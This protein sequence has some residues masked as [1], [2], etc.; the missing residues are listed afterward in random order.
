VL[1]EQVTIRLDTK[2]LAKLR[3]RAKER[4][5]GEAT[6]LARR[7]I[8]EGL[9]MDQYPGIVF[10]DGAAGRRPAL[11]GRRLG[12]APVVETL[13]ASNNDRAAT[14]EYFEIP[15]KEVEIAIAYYVDHKE[16]ID[17]WLE[18]QHKASLEQREAWERQ[19]SL[20]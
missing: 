7:Y 16:E 8:E 6:V 17:G 5:N 19:R 4:L 2:V 9:A 15:Q 1:G 3:K 12:V 18:E 14:S 13:R 10:R 20:V 11:A